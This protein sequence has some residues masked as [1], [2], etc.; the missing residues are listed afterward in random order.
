MGSRVLKGKWMLVLS[1]KIG[2][3]LHV[4]P[5]VVI[6]ISRVAGNRVT[7]GIEAPEDICVVRGELK[8]TRDE[9]TAKPAAAP[10]LEQ[11]KAG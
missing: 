11:A 7:I 2:E 6:V 5:D 3:R 4:G 1:R 8:P 9:L 10:G